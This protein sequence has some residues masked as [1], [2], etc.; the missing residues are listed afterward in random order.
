MSVIVLTFQPP[1]TALATGD[2]FPPKIRPLPKGSS[3]D[4]GEQETISPGT[5]EITRSSPVLKRSVIN[6]P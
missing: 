5:A 6:A 2:M 3:K 4:A 1:S